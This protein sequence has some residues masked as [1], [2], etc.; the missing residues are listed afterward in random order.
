MALKKRE[1]VGGCR[2]CI[3]ALSAALLAQGGLAQQASPSAEASVVARYPSGSIH[4]VETAEL[5]LAEVGKERA[6]VEQRFAVEKNACF[7]RFFASS[8]EQDAK[9]RRRAAIEKLKAV[10]V[11]ANAFKRQARVDERDQALEEKRV[12]DEKDRQ[13]RMLQLEMNPRTPRAEASTKKNETDANRAAA[14]VT[15]RKAQ[16]EAKL[17]RI[18]A[19]EAANA[20]K[21]AENTAAYQKK[22]Q[23]AQARQ[24]EVENRKA[25]K[26]RERAKQQVSPPDAK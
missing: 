20:Q 5:A 24:K 14:T 9:E 2:A 10:E 13:E 23:E 12:Q 1:I 11:E 3:V 18:E 25:E 6:Q 26:E 21:R 22:V 4:S 17:K 15:D 7:S 19:D 8:C 16:H